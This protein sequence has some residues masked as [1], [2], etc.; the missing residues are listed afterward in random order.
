MLAEIKFINCSRINQ[1]LNNNTY[2]SMMQSTDTS[3]KC[4]FT[5]LRR[6]NVIMAYFQLDEGARTI[7]SHREN[8][9]STISFAMESKR[10]Y[11]LR[12][13]FPL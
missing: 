6:V 9:N 2:H 4:P 10:S 7:E 13:E 8:H 3:T 11:L 12:I 5:F 1:P